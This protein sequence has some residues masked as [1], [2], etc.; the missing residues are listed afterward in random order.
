MTERQW[1]EREILNL[2]AQLEQRLDRIVLL[3]HELA[4]AYDATIEGWSRALDL[5]DKET[6]GHSRRVTDLTLR[7]AES[8]RHRH[9]ELV[10]IRRGALLHDIG[11]MGVP[12][13]ILLKPGPLTDD[14]WP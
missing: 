1:A 3:N 6:E 12:D 11:K 14:E 7:L 10:H 5:R 8:V 4:Q 9:E 2:N 13:A